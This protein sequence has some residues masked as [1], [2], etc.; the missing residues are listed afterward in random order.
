MSTSEHNVHGVA[1]GAS[2]NFTIDPKY[3]TII[4]IFDTPED[5]N[6]PIYYPVQYN[7]CADKY[8]FQI[9][10]TIEGH[11]MTKCNDIQIHFVNIKAEVEVIGDEV[12]VTNIDETSKVSGVYSVDDQIVNTGSSV[13][14]GLKFTWTVSDNATQYS[15]ILAF[16][17]HFKCTNGENV[18]YSWNT[19]YYS[20]LYVFK[21][22][23]NTDVVVSK[24]TDVLQQWH[25]KLF[26]MT[27]GT[28]DHN[29]GEALSFWIGTH[30]E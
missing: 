11:D 10:P 30:A 5:E 6:K 9:P 13:T 21:G 22:I 14:N 15:G 26:E 24:Y 16:A 27:G 2:L 19:R 4:P 8:T 7:H 25:A 23:N 18:E 3:K 12:K 20:N 1:S 28:I 17:I 29:T